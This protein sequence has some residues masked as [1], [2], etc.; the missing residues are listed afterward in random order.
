[1]QRDVL[2][3]YTPQW[4]S[5]RCAATTSSTAAAANTNNNNNT[6]QTQAG[7]TQ[8]AGYAT[9]DVMEKNSAQTKAEAFLNGKEPQ[10]ILEIF[11]KENVMKYY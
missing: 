4:K 3:G 5:G 8:Q 2:V 9:A 10:T 11:Q 1:M 6:S 7:P